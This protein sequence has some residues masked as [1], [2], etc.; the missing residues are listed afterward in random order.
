MKKLLFVLIIVLFLSNFTNVL[1]QTSKCLYVVSTPDS[2]IISILSELGFSVTT[3]TAI[4]SDLS[5]YDLVICREYSSCTPSTASY[6]GDY[7]KNSGGAILMGGTPSTF[8]GGG[9]SCS[10]ISD[11]FGTSQYSNVGLSDAKVSFDN[12]LETSLVTDDIIEHC[13]GWGGAAVTNVAQDV[14]VLA[15]WDWGTGNIHSFIRSYLGGRVAFWA[16]NASYNS[17]TR[18]LFK[19]ICHWSI[20]GSTS[21]V[22][23]LIAYYPF[24]GNANDESGNGHHG[25]VYNAALT[26]DRF[27]NSNRAYNFDGQND[28][29]ELPKSRDIFNQIQTVCFWVYFDTE[30]D[31]NYNLDQRDFIL[32]K[33]HDTG[34][35]RDVFLRYRD[36]RISN[37]FGTSNDSGS[38]LKTNTVFTKDK[39]Y[40]VAF[41]RT[42]TTNTVYVN[43][44]LDNSNTYSGYYVNDDDYLR[45]GTYYG[46]PDPQPLNRLM[47]GKIDDIYIY[48]KAFSSKE[49][50]YLY[51]KEAPQNYECLY[52]V[53]TPDQT[54]SSILNELELNVAV[55][56]MI[57]TDL[58]SYDLVICCEYSSC[59]PST[60]A[61]VGDY[62]KNGGGA[63]LMGG[64]PSTFCGGGYSCSNISDWFGTSQYSNVGLSDAKVSFDNPLETSL[65][66]DDI[67]EHCTGWGG[68]AVIN[69]AQD[70]TVLAEWDYG[71]G[72]IHSFIRPY[73]SG[74]VAFWA[75][76]ASYNSK[77]RELFKAVCQWSIDRNTQIDISPENE[78]ARY[79]SLSQ[80]FP[81][82][83]NPLTNI[84]YRI[85]KI[86]LTKLVI[87]NAI[88]KKIKVLVNQ[89]QS[90]GNYTII[91][92]GKDDYGNRV[93]SG[94][95]VY[96][97]RVNGLVKSRRML[98]LK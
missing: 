55:S 91:W 79:F 67:I 46:N 78:L 87:Y 45:I 53:S 25:T 65:V 13:T 75:G 82:P 84:A 96:Q 98:L 62:V 11:W 8:G 37:S 71:T 61:Y 9:Y 38:N 81:N 2:T 93:S 73:L 20:E 83:F 49:V 57:P 12:P 21:T 68:A 23:G 66:T 85:N 58:S 28:Y 56:T 34:Y 27:N 39:W 4:P 64:T 36:N 16:G 47:K 24:N 15:E 35:Q 44:E 17:K 1:S 7:V 6:V 88:G 90:P 40:H 3:S 80:N 92:D 72:N 97:L 50:W 52:V 30:I 51:S 48:N 41:V 94:V 32:S 86:G 33:A 70:V 77:T 31:S 5:S 95:Y 29:I 19:A 18:E 22:E 10:N 63:I 60:A 14:T 26:N 89:K 42:L 59:T 74:R 43:G 69:V 54:V 76:N